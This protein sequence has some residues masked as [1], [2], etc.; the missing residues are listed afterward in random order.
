MIYIQIS[1]PGGHPLEIQNSQSR[2][3]ALPGTLGSRECLASENAQPAAGAFRTCGNVQSKIQ[4]IGLRE[5]LQ[6]NP[7]FHGKIYGFLQIFFSTN[8]LRTEKWM[9][10]FLE[11]PWKPLGLWFR[12]WALSKLWKS[13]I[14]GG[15]ELGKSPCSSGFSSGNIIQNWVYLLGFDQ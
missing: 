9:V 3:G 2:F 12:I 7:M 11:T 4:W 14:N 15:L 8:P 5:E 6:E 13:F 1:A 10:H